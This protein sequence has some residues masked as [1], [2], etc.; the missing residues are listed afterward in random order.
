V[1]ASKLSDT[2]LVIAASGVCF[3]A[4]VAGIVA[5]AGFRRQG[6][7]LRTAVRI[8]A[9]VSKVH[10]EVKTFNELTIGQL[11]E[12]DETRRIGDIPLEDRTP[13]EDRHMAGDVLRKDPSGP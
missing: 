12:A 11:G 6:N 13:R 7:T 8:E 9:G 3:T 2:A 10:Q 5:I 4:H 1:I